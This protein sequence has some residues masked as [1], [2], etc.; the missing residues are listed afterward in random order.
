MRTDKSMYVIMQSSKKLGSHKT[1]YFLCKTTVS[2]TRLCPELIKQT[3][4][5]TKPQWHCQPAACWCFSRKQL[6]LKPSSTAQNH[7]VSLS[8][9]H[10][11]QKTLSEFIPCSHMV[12]YMK[13]CQFLCGSLSPCEIIQDFRQCGR[14]HSKHV[15]APQLFAGQSP[16]PLLI[17]FH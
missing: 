9:A 13:I 1:P 14:A 8:R 2:G 3:P 15:W 7:W 5:T 6:C 12:C 16:A 17:W 10:R 4:S 11:W